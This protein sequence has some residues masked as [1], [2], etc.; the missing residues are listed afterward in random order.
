VL[1]LLLV[2]VLL[3][4]L[5]LRRTRWVWRELIARLVAAAAA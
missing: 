1:S 3:L 5:L 4:V 2:L